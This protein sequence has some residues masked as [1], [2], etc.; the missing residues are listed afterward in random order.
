[1][2]SDC[3]LK[4]M[5]N[6]MK[7]RR[8][9]IALATV[10]AVLL[11]AGVCVGLILHRE[12]S[13]DELQKEALQKIEEHRGEYDE[14]S[15]V[16]YNTNRGEAQALAERFNAKLRI[17]SDG[18][19]ATLT[20][21][22]DVTVEDIYSARGNRK[23][24][25]NMA[26]D[27]R[28]KTSELTDAEEASNGERLPMRPQYTVRDSD[29]TLQ[30]YLDYLN[31]KSVWNTTQGNGITVAVIDTGIDTDHPEFVGRIS[32]YSYNATEDKIVKDYLLADGSYDWSLIEDE[33]GHG[34][35]V[36]GVIAASMN[37]TGVV[38]IA[39]QASIIV[40][41]AECDANGTFARTSDL[42]FGLYY[43]IERDASVVNMS[44]GTQ[45]ANNPF[46]AATQLA[47]DSGMICVAATGNEATTALTYPAADGNVFGIGALEANGWGLASY[48]N[49]GENVDLVAPGTTYTTLMG[50]TYGNKSGTSLAAPTVTGAIA[51]YLSTNQ[52]QDH[53]AVEEL[54]Y[55][56]CY[57]LGDLGC[58]WYY[59][60]GALDVSAL[61]LEE[62][63]TVTFNMM[64]DE[65][66]NTEQIFIRNHTLQS[67]PEPERLYAI[68]DGWY[69]DPECTDE[70]NSYAD[71]F[72]ADLTLYAKWVNEEDGI[73]YT[74][75]ELEDGTVEIRSY[76]GHR[77][78]LTIPDT[79]DGKIISSIGEEAFKG[80]TRLREVILPRS[81]KH[82]K[83][84]A[85]DGCSNLVH[86]EIP[87]TVVSIGERAFFDN[88]RL[89]YVAFG[90]NS[91]LTGI[92]A[93][94]F[95]NC[96]GLERFELP[97]A[98]ADMDGSAFFGSTNLTSFSVR[99]GNT[100]FVAK[101]GVLFNRT[102]SR[103]IC[104]PA[105]ERGEYAIP[106]TVKHIGDYAF[107][108]TRLAQIDLSNVQSIGEYAFAYS[109]LEDI[110]IPDSVS[111]MGKYAFANSFYL[112]SVALGN[113]LTEISPY[114]FFSCF[115]L[116]EVE[117]PAN[118]RSI[119]DGA[120]A[121][122][123]ALSSVTFAENSQ[124]NQIGGEAFVG[125]GLRS[126][127]IPASVITIDRAAFFDTP[128]SS[129]SFAEGSQLKTIGSE[130]FAKDGFLTEIAL[131]DQLV[132]IGAYAFKETDLRTVTVPASV[133]YLGEGAFAACHSLTDITVEDGNTVY[134]DVDGVVYDNAITVLVAYPA[135]N[136]RTAYTVQNTATAIGE[137]AFY[138]AGNLNGITLPESL[139][140]IRGEAFYRCANLRAMQIPDNVTQI[141]NR[142]FAEN[143]SLTSVTFGEGSKLPRIGYEAFAY[144]GLTAL[145]VPANV[146][147]VAQGAFVGC[148]DLISLTFARNSK[149][150]SISAYMLDGCEGLQTI[151]FESGSALT[152]IQA[153]GF[154]GM[155]NL[156]SIDFGDA[157]LTNIDNFAFRFCESLTRF[158]VP[159]GVTSL[160]RYVFYYCTK[161]SEVAI[162][163]SV[164]HIGRFAF[165]GAENVN[166]YFAAETLP[167][168]LEE[169]WDHGIAGYYLGVT[170]VIADGDW[171]Y[172]KL[173]GGDVA[174]IEYT[175][176]A[177]EIDLSV[178][179][180]GGKIVN[181]GG[182]TFAYAAV[183]HIVLPETLVTIQAE[184]FYHSALKSLTV[185]AS[186]RFI[187]RAAFAETPIQELT[188][189][190][191]SSLTV[192]EQSAFEGTKQLREVA[193]P[194]SLTTIGRAIFKNSGISS[195]TFADGIGI[196]EISEE[197]FS[198]TN[199]M[200]LTLPDRVT[201]IDHN[202]FRETNSLKTVVFGN[203]S[204]IMIMSNAFYRSGLE[205]LTIPAN[206]TYVGEYAF[207]ALFNLQAFEVD[208][209]NPNYKSVDGLLLSKNG[210]KLIAAPAGR[211]GTLTVPSGIEVIGYGAFEDSRL[212]RIEFLADANI[213]SFGYRAFY[214]SAVTQMHVP[215]SVVSID[216]YAFAMCEGLAN[217][218][219]AEGNR[220]RGVYEGAFYGC[221][222]L[223]DIALPDTVTEISDF[224]FY[225]CRK[226]KDLPVSETSTVKGIYDYAF[227]YTGL[228]GDFTVPETLLEIGA[229]AFMGNDF[230]AVTIPDTNA[231]DLIIGIGAFEECNSLEQMTVPFIGA[232]FEDPDITW[233]GYIFGA[234]GYEANATYV[235]ESLKRVSI[236]E[237][238][239]F[240]GVAAFY[241]L[242]ML[243]KLDIPHSVTMLQLL[244]FAEMT[245]KYELTNTI[246]LAVDD[247]GIPDEYTGGYFGKGLSGHLA[248]ADGVTTVTWGT[249]RGY[250][251]LTGITLPASVTTIEGMA[252]SDCTGLTNVTI[253]A[254]VTSIEGDVFSGCG[255]MERITV[256][257]GNTAYVSVDGILYDLPT[258][259]IISIPEGIGGSVHVP[260]GV[261]AIDENAF[262]GRTGL[263][264]I[265]L[266]ESLTSIGWQAF[267]GCS[268]LES[269]VIPDGVTSISGRAF[270]GCTSL[271]G[272]K[273]PAGLESVEAWVFSECGRLESIEIPDG[274]VSID[275]SAFSA[276]DALVKVTLPASLTHI[277][278]YAFEGC[279]LT[280]VTL[281]E[282][283]TTIENG[284]FS[285]CGIRILYNHSEIELTTTLMREIGILTTIN[286]VYDK[287][288]NITYQD[289][290]VEYIETQDG[291]LFELDDGK[292][293]LIAYLGTDEIV[294]LPVDING[295]TYR[296]AMLDVAHVVIPEGMTEIC[297]YMFSESALRTITIPEGVTSIGEHAFYSSDRLQTVTI[298]ASVTSIGEDAFASCPD[299]QLVVD[300]N[301]QSFTYIDGILYDKDVTR[302]LFVENSLTSVCIP[303]TVTDLGGAFFEHTGLQT[304]SF[305][306]GSVMTELDSFAFNGCTALSSVILPEGIERIGSYVFYGCTALTDIVL[307]EGLTDIGDYAFSDCIALEDITLPEGLTTIGERAFYGCS[308]L[309]S[310][311]IPESVTSI[312]D[313]AF[314]LCRALTSATLPT[315]LTSIGNAWFCYCESLASITIPE[316]VTSIGDS[317][318]YMCHNLL[319]I[320]IPEGVTS[321]GS[322]AFAYCYGLVSLTLPAGLESIEACAFEACSLTDITIP[323]GVTSIGNNAFSNSDLTRI[324]IPRGV[325]SIGSGAFSHCYDLSEIVIPEGVTSIG[326]MAFQHCDSLVSITIPASVTSLGEKMFDECA[327]L[328]DIEVE[329]DNA[330]YVSVD[331]ILYNRVTGQIIAIPNLI[332]GTVRIPDGM[333][334][335]DRYTFEA[336]PNINAF[337]VG[338]EHPLY[339]SVDGILYNKD[340]T[341]IIAVPRGI[342]GPVTVPSGVTQIPELAF[343]HCA[344][345]MGITLPDT[346]KEIG[347]SAFSGCTALTEITIPGG[348]ATIGEN[349][350]YGCA[351]LKTFVVPDS[352][353]SL[354]K[355]VFGYCNSLVDV[356]IGNGVTSIGDY[357]FEFCDSLSSV[358]LGSGLTGIGNNVLNGGGSNLGIVY[359][360]SDLSILPGSTD[361]GGIAR[362]ANLVID[363]NGNEIH[364]NPGQDFF[365]IDTPD[366]FR[367]RKDYAYS[368][369][370]Y[371]GSEETVTLPVD[372]NGES[373]TIE[374]LSGIRHLIIP[375]GVQRIGYAAFSDC[376][377]L[378]SVVIPGSVGEIPQSAFG[379]CTN[380]KSVTIAEGV[381]GIGDW[382]F[383]ACTS[384]SSISIPDSVTYV[385]EDVFLYTALYEDASNWQG[386]MLIIEGCLIEIPADTVYFIRKDFRFVAA[387]AF[388]GCYQVKHVVLKGSQLYALKYL[389]N[390]ETVILTDIQEGRVLE[391][392]DTLPI[393]LKN[394][395]IAKGVNM[396]ANAFSRVTGVR[397]YVEDSE[398]D[399]GWDDN[400]PNWHNGNSVVYGDDWIVA[401][402][403]DANG[404][405]L[406]SRIYLTSQVIRQPYL[407]LAR[408]EQ[409]SDVLVGWDLDGDGVADPVPATSTVDISARPIVEKR[410]TA[411]T[412]TFYAEDGTSVISRTELPYGGTIVP[413]EIAE[414]NGYTFNGWVG[415]RVGMT[416]SSDHSFVLDRTHNG[417]SHVYADAEWIEPTCT[418][419]GYHKHTCTVCGEWYSTD[420]VAPLGHSYDVTTQNA[421][422]TENGS[423]AYRCSV[424][425]DFYSEDIIA[426]GHSYTAETVRNATCTQMGEALYTCT[427]C[428]N[429]ETEQT[430]MLAHRYQRKNADPMWFQWLT[431]HITDLF[432]GHDGNDPYYFECTDCGHIQTEKEIQ[433]S[434][435]PVNEGCD[436][437]LGD[438]VRIT[439]T[440]CRIVETEGRICSICNK[441]IEARAVGVAVDH[442]FAEWYEIKTPTCT[443]EGSM[444]RDCANCDWYETKVADALGHDYSTEWTTDVPPTCTTIGIKSHHCSRCDD[445][446]DVTE[447][448]ANGHQFDDDTDSECNVCGAVRELGDNNPA[449]EEPN[450]SEN[451]SKNESEKSKSGCGASLSNGSAMI[452]LIALMGFVMLR[453]RKI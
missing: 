387:D 279:D 394:I 365:Y 409:Y 203:A 430:S 437:A 209:Q 62:R 235:P 26:L 299:L 240:L 198:Y 81:L 148:S 439:D 350:F 67:M 256:A 368:L 352:V 315:S 424:C 173:T 443:E 57:D 96:S 167:V 343:Y 356:V 188:F 388:A 423:A 301:N 282:N 111:A 9:W 54:L 398:K 223:R 117:I 244:A 232:S 93:M 254:S 448:P 132:Q 380:L 138:G 444:Q 406:S 344:S 175:G 116:G 417:D 176:P 5:G 252:F 217:V 140:Q 283:L 426:H 131:P 253:P 104:Y 29:Y 174:I 153:H 432:F 51:L 234:G 319:N 440:V 100:V 422:C 202:A 271:E 159:E 78:Y 190:D 434:S 375:E 43:A 44:F 17:S 445:R 82:I 228:D 296:V 450:S 333:S 339:A 179:D 90:G 266:P 346:L 396:T 208:A 277:G 416:V 163:T 336:Y 141:S 206:V 45:T 4:G 87:D 295:S 442:S 451:D 145:Y 233:F 98:L 136:A 128:L 431:E 384:L 120:F 146:S 52:N 435:A 241:D 286:T 221:K 360:N 397:I 289:T 10:L 273:L 180:L 255:N 192:M 214:G 184:A 27:Y 193:L 205:A 182:G 362:Y 374:R 149:L 59:G 183:E 196:T 302:I 259:Q 22:G 55:A 251:G 220:L 281:P 137:A 11:C 335:I 215:A 420:F 130:A 347:Y 150:E 421:T 105:G 165:L 177:T 332:S 200:S 151:T 349:A 399:T 19:F 113:G 21:R 257:E 210:R 354:G 24:I 269:L 265:T 294:T 382:A 95:A 453:K 242:A 102:A 99:T 263:T 264:S 92:G 393:T 229:H 231:Y 410:L 207:V 119:D 227:A 284:A 143:W 30:T 169:D 345:L 212:T 412:V 112:K 353:T 216:Y 427:V 446:A 170:D 76:T 199:I 70:Y 66:E 330:S 334:D 379:G 276:C 230:T 12:H 378:E 419:Q 363:K 405:L 89:S 84:S 181:I 68:F 156:T 327:N 237:G 402:F 127:H 178:L 247:S 172:A 270:M 278:S 114:A 123:D 125:S 8:L 47:Y 20:L 197:A 383:L 369:I 126:I 56:S 329:T 385:G 53:D 103:L 16:L 337:E 72:S 6:I 39:P 69:Y 249:F 395:V 364:L 157:K 292:Y 106:D 340:K 321:I 447:L 142:A 429:T 15:I 348:V 425:G 436:H 293:T 48:S 152:S 324:V 314:Y 312:E 110:V 3:V 404:D 101:D 401:D 115:M 194:K 338:A 351:G 109:A 37:D 41:K 186:V 162:P 107:G 449:P 204:E 441:V 280:S 211:E 370:A 23:Y 31:M 219:F 403:Y 91:R 201:L 308:S 122:L 322:S 134:V 318:F 408:G 243:E 191:A 258:T 2:I 377:V 124:L 13:L 38:G 34:T 79:V 226:L 320:T 272:I 129:V 168:D 46:A 121:Y 50:G 224:A 275:S 42:V 288:G 239:S 97:A 285:G 187:G 83:R 154:E 433:I 28:V 18:K 268:G 358:T 307:P 85:F 452:L 306:Q 77:R 135:G 373:Y 357:M 158:D 267:Y 35:A 274:V 80:Q 248:L 74:Y 86:I 147:T 60:Y 411:Y 342:I 118:I 161:L 236:N 418:E 323:N 371:L 225:G 326:D 386:G 36:T 25:S 310:I 414:K 61:I 185:P 297:E 372:I 164:E 328:T 64:S 213:L 218:T 58:D 316:G 238:I 304:V 1:M 309:K 391:F 88:V 407:V 287:D 300:E 73:P 303:S 311:T 75:V 317:A 189:A 389:T 14:R 245:A 381:T 246:L 133:T 94:A 438:W 400:F 331:G 290:D 415:Y 361:H 63:G 155:R 65:L 390:V 341:E 166:V 71:E 160:G 305:E 222:D 108:Y 144:C 291:F 33:Q 325:T 7:K 262:S 171:K 359:N 139:Q 366:G 355:S 298:P 32:E 49:Y 195:L 261:T 260:E 367:F 313:G 250:V 40:I 376:V 392:D 413:P 428:G